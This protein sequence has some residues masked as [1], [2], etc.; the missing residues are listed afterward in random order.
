[1]RHEGW[2]ARRGAARLGTLTMHRV[3]IKI[4]FACNNRC[5]FCVQG[6]K[7]EHEPPRAL[8]RIIADL[9]VARAGGA[10][11]VV[12]TGGEPTLQP[13]LLAAVR[14]AS[15]L[16]FGTIQVQTN[17]RRLAYRDYCEALIEAGANEFSPA[18]HGARAE[19]H[20][21]HTGAAGSYAQTLA[22]IANLVALGQTVITNSVVTARN[23][24]ELPE[25]ARLLVEAGVAQFQFAFVHILGT[26]AQNRAWI[27]PR[28][29]DVLP[30][31]HAGLEVGRRAGVRSYTEAI[32]L[33]LMTGYEE[34]VAERIIPSTLI[35]DGERVVDDYTA[36]RRDEG[37]AKGPACP[38]CRSFGLCEGPWREYPQLFGWDEFRPIV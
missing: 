9:R 36:Y 20:D 5:T 10:Q 22:G 16:G 2:R 34:H 6:D 27:V 11:G 18:L 37:K 12:F 29:S 19:T 23:G 31:V 24:S 14:A 7:R 15:A 32:P 17:G 35:F 3:D 28:K 8:E 25:L 33:C 30:F 38:P 1:M 26:A 13:T 21:A 4:G